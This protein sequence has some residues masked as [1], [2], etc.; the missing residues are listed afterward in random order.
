MKKIRKLYQFFGRSRIKNKKFAI[1]REDLI[2][3]YLIMPHLLF[4]FA[5]NI[6]KGIYTKN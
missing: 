4:N 3:L 1:K 6:F 2:S 5:M